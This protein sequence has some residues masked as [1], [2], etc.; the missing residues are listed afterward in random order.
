MNSIGESCNELKKEYDSCFHAWFSNKFL[1]GD[2]NESMC[3]PLFKIYQQCVK[4]AMKEH[5][6]ELKEIEENHIE[7]KNKGQSES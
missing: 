7:E 1:K 3:E 5:K 2:T 6:I 4:N